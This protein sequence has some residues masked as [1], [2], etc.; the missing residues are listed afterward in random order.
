MSILNLIE[1][2]KAAVVRNV[3]STHEPYPLSKTI[4]NYMNF[5][6]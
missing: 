5:Y 6:L 3:T 1:V 2:D 4:V